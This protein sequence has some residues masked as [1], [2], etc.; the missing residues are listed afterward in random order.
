MK[1]IR[2]SSYSDLIAFQQGKF[3]NR[4]GAIQVKEAWIVRELG[5]PNRKF[6]SKSFPKLFA[7]EK[8]S[9]PEKQERL[10]LMF[11]GI[12]FQSEVDE[13]RGEEKMAESGKEG[14]VT[15]ISLRIARKI[16]REELKTREESRK[17]AIAESIKAHPSSFGRNSRIPNGA[18]FGDG[19]LK[20]TVKVQNFLA[21]ERGDVPGWV[22]VVLMT[23]GL[24]TGIWTVAEPR[25][26]SI[27]KNSLD[28]M[29]SIR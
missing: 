9:T 5:V 19:L 7:A 20:A 2:V 16:A 23:T 8:Q 22:L 3:I 13:L 17:L 18:L 10:I 6:E 21:E 4:A 11:R 26:S 29:N 25:L 28:N 27:L 14:A 24:V 1:Y 15:D 12:R